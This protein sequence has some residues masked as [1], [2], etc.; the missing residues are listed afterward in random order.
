MANLTTKSGEGCLFH[1]IECHSIRNFLHLIPFVQNYSEILDIS[2]KMRMISLQ[3]VS[4]NH[5]LL[6]IS[7]FLELYPSMSASALLQWQTNGT[8]FNISHLSI[9]KLLISHIRRRKNKSHYY[10]IYY[11]IHHSLFIFRLTTRNLSIPVVSFI[12]RHIVVFC[13]AASPCNYNFGQRNVIYSCGECVLL[14][15]LI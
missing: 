2:S 13:L 4:L 10:N 3:I 15:R 14:L 8:Q 11:I 1:S 7:V 12:V 9:A 6:T 5:T